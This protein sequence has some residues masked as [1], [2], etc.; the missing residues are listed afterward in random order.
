LAF[1]HSRLV[2]FCALVMLAALAVAWM[3]TAPSIAAQAPRTPA[4]TYIMPTLPPSPTPICGLAPRN[5]LIVRERAR[6][7]IEDPRPLNIRAGAGTSFD[8]IGQI[9]TR[10]IFY[11][12]EGPRCSQRY[13]WYR[14]EYGELTGWI[15]E[16]DDTAYF[17]EV[18]PPG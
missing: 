3:E 4:P 15:A 18:Y 17:V 9:P 6:V 14:V 8:V 12:L 16:G 7:S 11:V 13:S 5:R 10:G 1:C 2:I